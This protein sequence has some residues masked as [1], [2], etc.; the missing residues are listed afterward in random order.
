MRQP[1]S[2]GPPRAGVLYPLRMGQQERLMEV[3]EQIA[4]GRTNKL[5]CPFCGGAE[6]EKGA[7]DY[8]PI[9]TC[10]A[11]RRFIEAPNLDE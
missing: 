8:G 1:A 7:G 2:H 6:L 5:V 11:C 9:F 3:M 10:P 4:A